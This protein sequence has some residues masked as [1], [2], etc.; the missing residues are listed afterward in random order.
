M[1]G[2]VILNEVYT[3]VVARISNCRFF[4]VL[5]FVRR[6]FF[7]LVCA[8]N[9]AFFQR[10]QKVSKRLFPV[11]NEMPL[12]LHRKGNA[13]LQIYVYHECFRI[14][15]V[16]LCKYI[17]VARSWMN[18]SHDSQNFTRNSV[19]RQNCRKRAQIM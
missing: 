9:L 16:V 6:P 8:R 18:H 5:P 12:K 4:L 13:A 19:K 17:V 2:C 7:R 14:F 11:L 15:F 10:H 1:L 3:Y